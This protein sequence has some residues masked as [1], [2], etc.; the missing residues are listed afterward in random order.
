MMM[1]PMNLGQFGQWL[2][3]HQDRV[4]TDLLREQHCSQEDLF[5]ML[6]EH[7][8]RVRLAQGGNDN[9]SPA[10]ASSS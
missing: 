2:V 9:A 3:A 10:G 5:K 8:K 4:F 6:C 7:L 1:A